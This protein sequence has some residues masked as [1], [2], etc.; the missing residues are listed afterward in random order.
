MA[1]R[2]IEIT[3]G[4]FD[5]ILKDNS[6][7]VVDCWAPWCG[8]CRMIAPVIDA[9]SEEYQNVTF[10]KLNTDENLDISRKFQIMAIPT[11]LFFKD[12][13]LVERITGVVPKGHIENM[14]MKYL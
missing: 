8:P 4:T 10:G 5:S 12:G 11:L 6:L 13:K 2:T 1:A 14:V 9:L 3:D 7:V